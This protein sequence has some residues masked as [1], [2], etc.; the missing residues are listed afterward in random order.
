MAQ[1][2]V[3]GIIIGSILVLGS[4]GLTLTYGVLRF[5]NFAHGDMMTLGA[6]VAFIL[7]GMNLPLGLVFILAMALTALAG[8]FFDAVL[9]KPLRKKGSIVLLIASVGVALFLRNLIQIIWGPQMRY[10]STE[11]QIAYTLPFG[12]RI[13]PD[14]LLIIFTAATLI[15]LVHLFLKKTRIGKAMRAMSDNVELAQIAGIDTEKIVIW[16]WGI[17]CALAAAAGILL[18]IEVQLRPLMGWEL[19][20]PIFAAVILGGI[21]KPYGAMVGGLIIGLSQ[22]ISTAFISTAYKPAVSF[23]ILILVLFIKPSGIFAK[24]ERWT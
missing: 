22:E 13:K 12:I 21:G 11:I 2:I 16:T 3:N 1:L 15:I 8:V 17:G 19:L 20:L 18:G 7:V 5:A 9:Y 24:E 14:Q 4:V 10:Y 23:I 6:Y